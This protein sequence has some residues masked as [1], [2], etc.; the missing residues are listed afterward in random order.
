[1]KPTQKTRKNDS[2]LAEVL[3]RADARLVRAQLRGGF[4]TAEQAAVSEDYHEVR[5]VLVA[6]KVCGGISGHAEQET[7]EYLAEARAFLNLN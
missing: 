1:M 7:R 6:L 4:Y 3:N 2:R 5:R